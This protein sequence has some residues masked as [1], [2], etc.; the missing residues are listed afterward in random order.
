M[1]TVNIPWFGQIVTNLAN[2]IVK[3]K[4]EKTNVQASISALTVEACL[5]FFSFP[6]FPLL[7]IS[8]FV[9][10]FQKNTRDK[11]VEKGRNWKNQRFIRMF[12]SPK[13]P[14]PSKKKV[15]NNQQHLEMSFPKK[16]STASTVTRYSNIPLFCRAHRGWA[17][18]AASCSKAMAIRRSTPS[19]CTTEVRGTRRWRR[20][21]RRV[22]SSWDQ[23]TEGCPREGSC[24]D[25]RLVFSVGDFTPKSL[26]HLEIYIS[27]WKYWS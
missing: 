3:H 19:A 27:R 11:R 8:P 9:Q 23:P 10:P 16:K 6:V 12:A 5:H 14:L 7:F 2:A 21:W 20:T 4:I 15:N 18:A 25:Q 24:W 13:N 26:H 22:R 17:S 1:P